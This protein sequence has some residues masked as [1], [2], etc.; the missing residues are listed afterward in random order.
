MSRITHEASSI[1]FATSVL[2]GLRRTLAE[3]S[4]AVGNVEAGPNEKQCAVQKHAHESGHMSYDDATGLPLDPKMVADAVKGEFM[5]M[6]GLHI[7]HEVPVSDLDK[8]ELKA[9]G[10]RWAYTIKGDAANPF[11]QQG[12]LRM[13]PRE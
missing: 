8:S 10:T 12:W 5:F 9:I 13:R 6:R 4:G 7:Y 3:I 1:A 11:T 2:R